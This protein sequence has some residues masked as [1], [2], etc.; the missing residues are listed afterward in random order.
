M[1]KAASVQFHLAQTVSQHSS[2]I[3]QTDLRIRNS[4]EQLMGDSLG[5]R[6][7]DTWGVCIL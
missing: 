5:S 7:M 4:T 2:L 6:S 1:L 3:Q